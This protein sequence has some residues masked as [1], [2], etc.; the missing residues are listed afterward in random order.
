MKNIN[1]FSFCFI[2]MY[3]K[4][5]R[6]KDGPTFKNVQRLQSNSIQN[7]ITSHW[8][9]LYYIHIQYLINLLQCN[10]LLQQ[11]SIFLLFLFF[12]F[13]IYGPSLEF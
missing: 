4:P 13:I 10:C 8:G 12:Y 11:R 7:L 6:E 2:R 5:K 3:D 9:Y 1:K